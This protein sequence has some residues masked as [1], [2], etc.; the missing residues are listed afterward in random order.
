MIYIS[1]FACL[2]A[3]K[4]SSISLFTSVF[5]LVCV[6]L[7]L[8]LLLPQ[9]SIQQCPHVDRVDDLLIFEKT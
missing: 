7:L 1:I 2:I 8:L 6:L 3:L 5:V 9:Q 4:I